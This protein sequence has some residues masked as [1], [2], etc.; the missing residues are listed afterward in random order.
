M[1]EFRPID[2]EKDI[3][4]VTSLLRQ[5]LSN[6]HNEE[7][8]KWKHLKNPFGKSYGW[9]ALHEGRVVG[10]RMFMI[11]QFQKEKDF[12]LAIRPVD[13]VTYKPLRG[14]GI[15]TTLTTKVLEDCRGKY[16]LIFNTPNKE[17]LPADKRLGWKEF[18]NKLFFWIAFCLPVF[19]REGKIED[20]KITDLKITEVEKESS[21]STVKSKEYL[22][23]RFRSDDY[24]VSVFRSVA[25]EVQLIY[26]IEKRKKIRMIVLLELIGKKEIFTQAVK[27]LMSQKK[28]FFVYFLDNCSTRLH[29]KFRL[30]R[31]ASAVLIKE[32]NG[33]SSKE[34]C[35]S[36]ADL[37]A[38]L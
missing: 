17:S 33:G 8:F 12:F 30:K 29:F 32:D 7:N 20:R 26:R 16:E 23:W 21:W 38:K 5:N 1:I 10:V 34:L 24:C 13:T 3:P 4:G 19:S 2:Y 25:G 31:R 15:F 22:Q 37:E 18:Q 35:F 14:I 9:I 28:I 11:W 6:D 36:A 27:K